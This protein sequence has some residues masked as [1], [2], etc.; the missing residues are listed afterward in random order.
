MKAI[1]SKILV[2][3]VKGE[4]LQERIGNLVV[5][6]GSSTDK[7]LCEVLSVGE[8]ID[9]LKPGDRVLAYSGAGHEFKQEGETYRVIA[10]SDILVVL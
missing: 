9:S 6:V 7:M 3:E 1:D 10:I 5:P 4:E 8:K 2:K